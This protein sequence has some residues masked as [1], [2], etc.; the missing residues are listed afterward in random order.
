MYTCHILC[1][2]V[3][4]FTVTPQAVHVD[5]NEKHKHKFMVQS[6][7]APEGKTNIDQVVCLYYIYV[8]EW[9]MNVQMHL[10]LILI[11]ISK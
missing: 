8:Y 6:V 4:K 2:L 7:I 10:T 11:C 5:S 9:E 1:W 3:L